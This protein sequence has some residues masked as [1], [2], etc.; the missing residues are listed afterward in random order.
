MRREARQAKVIS[1]IGKA[2]QLGQKQLK[3]TSMQ[4]I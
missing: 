3:K 4:S 1:E 2:T